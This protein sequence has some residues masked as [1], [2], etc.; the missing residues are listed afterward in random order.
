M[1]WWASYYQGNTEPHV[2][3]SITS[4]PITPWCSGT[5][6]IAVVVQRLCRLNGRALGLG[7]LRIGENCGEVPSSLMTWS[8]IVRAS[9]SKISWRPPL[10]APTRIAS[11][12][13]FRCV[14]PITHMSA[15]YL[16]SPLLRAVHRSASM[17]FKCGQVGN[18]AL[19]RYLDL[20][21]RQVGSLLG[22]RRLVARILLTT[23]TCHIAIVTVL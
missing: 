5:H 23:Q 21:L 14:L 12:K 11:I 19:H 6:R 17:I 1:Y 22:I 3:V 18:Q 2:Q 4:L 20:G 15:G 16:T 9:A 8:Q 7:G 10:S 13:P